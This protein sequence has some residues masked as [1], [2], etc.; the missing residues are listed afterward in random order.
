MA[1]A[2]SIERHSVLAG[3]RAASGGVTIAASGTACRISLRAPAESHQ[4]LSKVLDVALPTAPKG[5]AAKGSRAA[6]CLGPDEWLILDFD[7]RDPAADCANTNVPH[8][9]VDISHR[10]IGL[11]I[12]GWAAEAVLNAGCPRDL[13]LEAFPVG[14]CSRTVLGKVEVI[15]W[16]VEE[17]T[18]RLECWRSFA[19]YVFDLLALAARQTGR[20]PGIADGRL[21]EDKRRE[22]DRSMPEN[23]KAKGKSAAVRSVEK[24][25]DRE[26]LEEELEEGLEE[27]FPASD[28][29][30]V[31]RTSHIGRPQR[32][33]NNQ[34]KN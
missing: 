12:S 1:R 31:T 10:N 14:A 22:G 30:S 19:D 15:L 20:E 16:R 32:N 24:E 9:A 11:I 7:D 27:T 33:K 13:S 2:E 17:T 18:F 26:R 5:S 25:R 21:V 34:K 4:A 6:L 8:S 28:P 23:K 3:R 29:V